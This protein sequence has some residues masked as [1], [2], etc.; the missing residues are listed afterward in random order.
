MLS[1]HRVLAAV[2]NEMPVSVDVLRVV[3]AILPSHLYARMTQQPVEQPDDM[4]LLIKA[5]VSFWFSSAHKGY[6]H[7]IDKAPG[8]PTTGY[9]ACSGFEVEVD[10]EVLA[11]GSINKCPQSL[12]HL[13]EGRADEEFPLRSVIDFALRF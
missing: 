13:F 8:Q 12:H 7:C 10:P 11:C 2:R 5:P 3:K 9:V 4:R 1:H 6:R